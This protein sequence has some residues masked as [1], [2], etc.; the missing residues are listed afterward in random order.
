METSSDE[1]PLALFELAARH[2]A[3]Y[4]EGVRTRSPRAALEPAA[5]EGLFDGP[6][7]EEPEQAVAVLNALAAAADAGITSPTS[8]GFFGWVIGG[9]HPI[10]VAADMM[11]S[12]WGRMLPAS[13][14]PPRLRR[15]RKSVR[16]GC[17]IC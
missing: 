16:D 7:P 10:G 9:S 13:P 3:Q 14:A 12:A 6:T 2:A 8:P 15:P 17:W 4:R 5:V 1:T 11:T